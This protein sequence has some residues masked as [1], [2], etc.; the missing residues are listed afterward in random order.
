MPSQRPRFANK[1]FT[2]TLFD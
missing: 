2:N 1:H